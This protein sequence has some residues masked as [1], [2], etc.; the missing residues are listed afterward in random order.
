MQW[1]WRASSGAGMRRGTI[2]AMALSVGI[3]SSSQTLLIPALPLLSEER[4]FSAVANGWLLSTFLIAASL[5]APLAGRIGDLWGRRW[6]MIVLAA[7]HVVGATLCL[8]AGDSV[9]LMIGGRVFQ[10]I[11]AGIFVVHIS[12]LQQLVADPRRRASYIGLLSGVV[13]MGPAIGFLVGGIV[14]AR[15]GVNAIFLLVICVA[16]LCTLLL[17]LL[18]PDT[19][20]TATGRVDTVGAALVGI[21]FASFLAFFSELG[22][23]GPAGVT[24]IT[25]LVVTV[26]ATV[27]LVLWMRR[28]APTFVSLKAL[29]NRM[30]ALG[31]IATIWSAVATFGLF[32][33][34][35]QLIQDGSDAGLGLGPIAAGLIL[36]PGALAMGFIGPLAARIG[37]ARGYGTVIIVGNA[38]CALG[39][40][41]LAAMPATVLVVLL[42]AT[43]AGVGI[44]IA[45]PAMPIVV[46]NAAAPADVGAAAGINSLGRGIGSAVGAQVILVISA[47]WA[48][49]GAAGH[50][51]A[52]MTCA[53]C[54]GVAAVMGALIRRG[55]RS[56]W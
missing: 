17:A 24:T 55:E 34:V 10:G 20:A 14:A 56:P 5:A 21:S 52:F 13:A 9:W 22:V 48:Q 7:S 41:G 50:Q 18:V 32:V 19:S 2:G 8:V 15:F 16:C 36:A 33:A 26:A 3:P 49:N 39:L 6:L 27:C 44:G 37:A 4:G 43:L 40:V 53:I 30:S 42:L 47:V 1:S 12:A 45:F 23:A 46:M 51:A 11:S 28:D 25:A 29:R 38:L 54:A 31:N 35:P